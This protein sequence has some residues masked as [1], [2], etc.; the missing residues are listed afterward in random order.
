[1]IGFAVSPHGCVQDIL[2]TLVTM[3]SETLIN[4][5]LNARVCIVIG[6]IPPAFSGAGLCAYRYARR[7]HKTGRLAFVVAERPTEDATLQGPLCAEDGNLPGRV[8]RLP[9]R[10]FK[11]R[12]RAQ[13]MARHKLASLYQAIYLWLSTFYLLLRKRN[14]YD[15]M[16]GF[17]SGSQLPLFA[18]LTSRILG[19][20][21]I[22]RIS[23]LGT[24]DPMTLLED[25]HH[26]RHWLRIKAFFAANGY[27]SIS[28]PITE[29]CLKAGIPPHM[30]WEIPNPVD[31]RL[32]A[33]CGEEERRMLRRELGISDETFTTVFVG[34]IIWRKG[35]DL[36][37]DAFAQL[38]RI[39]D[40]AQLLIIGPRLAGGKDENYFMD[41]LD[42]RISMLG[43][44]KKLKF[45]GFVSN[46]HLY[47]KACDVFVFPS[48]AEGCA[49][50]LVEAMASG[51][52][53]I[54]CHMAGLAQYL[55]TNE[56]D[57]LIVDYTPEA[58][59]E[60]VERLYNAPDIRKKISANAFRTARSRF[61][62]DIVDSRYDRVY[63]AVLEAP[64]VR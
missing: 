46:V 8:F 22:L 59:A 10:R 64:K 31:V 19:K 44:S 7:L 26:L 3:K 20:K 45:I 30:V 9:K 1:V 34:G 28:S 60:A 61:A 48:R 50:V 39:C 25:R 14:E 16:F 2:S 21:A 49:N 13:R 24:D 37:I 40:D 53:V 43:L 12:Y 63:K 32:F 47:M 54:T 58:I 56:V 11:K 52:P 27:I 62:T 15:I 36:L 6:G 18:T 51:L 42:K 33:P 23:L 35:I 4:D 55:I 17:E 41:G 5:G 29:S 38:Y 57:G